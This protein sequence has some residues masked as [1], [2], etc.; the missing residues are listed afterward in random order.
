MAKIES[1]A[2]DD[3]V[4]VAGQLALND[5][6]AV[7]D[8]GFR[9]VVVLRPDGEAPGQPGH[10]QVLDGANEIG[11]EARY[12]PLTPGAWGPAEVRAFSLLKTTMPKPILAFCASG[13]RA[14][15]IWALSE[16]GARPKA[17]IIERASGAGVDLSDMEDLLG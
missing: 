12:L 7:R 4:S 6:R 9:S 5:L 14:A 13:R 2:L 3:E 1:M 10:R 11:L 17:D 16:A 15:T 8:E